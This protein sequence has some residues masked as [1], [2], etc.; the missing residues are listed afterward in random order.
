MAGLGVG[1]G[2]P[3]G[4]GGAGPKARQYVVNPL[5]D[6]SQ[7]DQGSGAWYEKD[8]GNVHDADMNRAL[9]MMQKGLGLVGGLTGGAGATA[10]TVP[11]PGRDPRIGAPTVK[12]VAPGQS[13]AFGRAKDA[14]SRLTKQALAALK[15]NMTARGTAGSGREDA[16]TADVLSDA[17]VYQSNAELMQQ[18][19]AE[20]QSWE[21]AKAGFEGGIAQRGQDYGV[22][23]AGYQGNIQQRGQTLDAAQQRLGLIPTLFNALR[24]Y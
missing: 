18:M 22:D 7:Y 21:A 23:Q 9:T 20:N 15:D 14:S 10:P 24:R 4:R 11:A 8:I 12:A 16:L 1:F 2:Q 5:G 17:A 6:V 19:A 13:E 3:T